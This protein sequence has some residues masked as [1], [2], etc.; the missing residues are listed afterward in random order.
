MKT[1]NT[2]QFKGKQQLLETAIKGGKNGRKAMLLLCYQYHPLFIKTVQK[3][4]RF[5]TETGKRKR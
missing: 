3:T 1:Y 2:K 4:K 5:R